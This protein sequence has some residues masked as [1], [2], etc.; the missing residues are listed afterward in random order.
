MHLRDFRTKVYVGDTVYINTRAK[1]YVNKSVTVVLKEPRRAKVRFED[2]TEKFFSFYSFDKEPIAET[3]YLYKHVN[4]IGNSVACPHCKRVLFDYK[5]T[6]LDIEA[7]HGMCKHC[8]TKVKWD[9]RE[10]R[11]KAEDY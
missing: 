8:G 5:N 4:I 10:A 1:N 11:K 3:A 7:A 2:G 6:M 9:L